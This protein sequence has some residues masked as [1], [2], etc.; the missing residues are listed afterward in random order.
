MAYR[1]S[2]DKQISVSTLEIN[3]AAPLGKKVYVAAE[4][5]PPDG[6]GIPDFITYYNKGTQYMESQFKIIDQYFKDNKGYGGIAIEWYNT[7]REMTI[8][9]P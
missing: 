7:Y 2:A 9:K 1:D 3:Y 8:K 5:S 6:N 4:T